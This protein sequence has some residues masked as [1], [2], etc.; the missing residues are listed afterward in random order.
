ME[1]TGNLREEGNKCFKE[2]QY[3]EALSL[4]TEALNLGD[5]KDSDR[6][7]IYKNQSACH[8]KMEAYT[9]AVERAT[10]GR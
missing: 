8:L 6:A 4:Y 3:G 9:A 5:L 10:A 7:V 1:D 2:G